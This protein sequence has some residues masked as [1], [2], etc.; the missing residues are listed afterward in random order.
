MS[1]DNSNFDDNQFDEYRDAFQEEPPEEGGGEGGNGGKR[2]N[3]PFIIAVA[4]IGGIFLL[5]V[6]AL[7]VY[8]IF[9]NSNRTAQVQEETSKIN[10]E[11]TAIAQQATNLFQNEILQLTQKAIPTNTLT[12]TQVI[13]VPTNTPAPTETTIAGQIG[14]AERTATVSA[15]LTSVAESTST[16]AGTPAATQG[17]TSTALPSTGIMDNVGLPGMLAAA[18]L[19]I[20]ILFV[21]RR[22]RLS[23]NS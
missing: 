19:L 6:I 12:P 10:A 3:R 22:I 20:I 16:A 14:D 8:I 11:N 2:N 15:F 1:E 5:A 21:A 7:V 9:T 13:A 4:V 17:A 18:V 23:T